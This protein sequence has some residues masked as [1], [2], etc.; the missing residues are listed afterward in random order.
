[1]NISIF[2]LLLLS[3][4]KT[5]TDISIPEVP[6]YID[7][8][9]NN[10]KLIVDFTNTVEGVPRISFPRENLPE[11]PV[12]E[13]KEYTKDYGIIFPKD[14]KK[15]SDFCKRIPAFYKINFFKIKPNS[16]EL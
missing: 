8:N 2:V 9:R 10:F 14:I 11:L 3:F 12:H 13:W 16:N 5:G 6:N 4:I 1:M 15:K 7:V